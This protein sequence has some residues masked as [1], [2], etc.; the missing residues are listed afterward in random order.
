MS[1]FRE[2]KLNHLQESNKMLKAA[3]EGVLQTRGKPAAEEY[4]DGGASFEL[5]VDAW[6]TAKAAIEFANTPPPWP[7][8][9][10]EE[11]DDDEELAPDNR[12]PFSEAEIER[13][14]RRLAAI[15]G[16]TGT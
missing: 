3:L 9:E 16:E 12:P 1:D 5:A 8:E 4:V 6:N 2:G 11:C 7:D 13:S 14:Q 15:L 10:D